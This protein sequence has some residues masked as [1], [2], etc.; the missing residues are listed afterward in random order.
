MPEVNPCVVTCTPAK[1][2]EYSACAEDLVGTN[3]YKERCD[4][5]N[6]RMKTSC[7]I[8]NAL[9]CKQHTQLVCA[10]CNNH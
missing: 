4:K 1:T 10:E 5:L 6:T 3:I 2:G 7:S 9:I 8:C